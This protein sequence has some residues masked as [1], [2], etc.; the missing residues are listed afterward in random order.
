M[1][2]A[3]NGITQTSGPRADKGLSPASPQ[4]SADQFTNNLYAWCFLFIIAV[5]AVVRL[6]NIS[7]PSLWWDEI[8]ASSVAKHQISYIFDR[9]L[10]IDLYSP[11]FYLVVKLFQFIDSSDT[12]ARLPY[13]IFGLIGIVCLYRVAMR[14]IGPESAIMAVAILAFNFDYLS[15]SR[16]VRPYVLIFILALLAFFYLCE[17]CKTWKTSAAYKLLICLSLLAFLHLSNLLLLAAA[18]LMLFAVAVTTKDK[19]ARQAFAVYCLGSLCLGAAMSPYILS[20]LQQKQWVDQTMTRWDLTVSLLREGGLLIFFD[21]RHWTQMAMATLAAIGFF[22]LRKK[23]PVYAWLALGMLLLPPLFLIAMKYQYRFF[24]FRHITFLLPVF[25][26]LAGRGLCFLV[27]PLGHA[28]LTAAAVFILGLTATLRLSQD[29]LYDE[30]SYMSGWKAVARSVAG[31][32]A[33]QAVFLMP[34]MP[35]ITELNWYLDNFQ[36]PSCLREPW[37]KPDDEVVEL[38][39]LDYRGLWDH[40]LWK[41]D[42]VLQVLPQWDEA[43]DLAPPDA[44]VSGHGV[45]WEKFQHGRLLIWRI[46]RSP[47]QSIDKLP[48]SMAAAL[49]PTDFYKNLWEARGVMLLPGERYAVIPSVNNRPGVLEYR[50]A[51][52]VPD[53][54]Q[55]FSLNCTASLLG[56]GNTLSVFYRFDDEPYRLAQTLNEPGENTVREFSFERRGPYHTFQVRFELTCG[57]QAPSFSGENLDTARLE[58][59]SLKIARLP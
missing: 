16:Q 28:P 52:A 55:M 17:L 58:D 22:D 57:Q 34:D 19:R 31:A 45:S 50:F 39:F 46:K 59:F 14:I 48:F 2:I 29:R 41:N 30:H 24:S 21:Y 40:G 12:M 53:C 1:A 18:G 27:R 38:N 15:M 47:E 36:T 4:V 5:S 3:S 6:Y 33:R 26:I 20:G 25:V 37:V 8:L 43:R 35:S 23:E 10:H 54:P 42:Q 56:P 44:A 11:L 51:N 7:V 49:L 32:P 13:V 9:S